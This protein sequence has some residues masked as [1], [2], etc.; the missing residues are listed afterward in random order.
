METF[1]PGS[2]AIGG[3]LI[4]LAAVLFMAFNGRVAGISGIVAGVLTPVRGDWLWRAAFIAGLFL[5]P[6][7]VWLASA[8][9]PVVAFSHPIWLTALGG[10]AVGFGARLGGGCTSGHGVCGMARLSRRSI[11]ATATFMASA[12]ATVFLLHHVAGV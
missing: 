4:G 2:A 3:M 1:T 8:D 5:A 10:L 7:F 9:K 12:I 6:F 11:A